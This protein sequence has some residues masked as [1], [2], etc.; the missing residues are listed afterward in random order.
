MHPL[1]LVDQPEHSLPY[2]T[3]L[4]SQ[5]PTGLTLALSEKP[6]RLLL[7]RLT[8]A[9]KLAWG[10]AGGYQQ[11]WQAPDLQVLVSATPQ[12]LPSACDRLWVYPLEYHWE[13]EDLEISLSERQ[14]QWAE[15]SPTPVDEDALQQLLKRPLSGFSLP[16]IDPL[17]AEVEACAQA[18]LQ[19]EN[20]ALAW[21]SELGARYRQLMDL[22]LWQLRLMAHGRPVIEAAAQRLIDKP[23]DLA[24]QLV[25]LLYKRRYR[26][27]PDLAADH[28]LTAALQHYHTALGSCLSLLAPEPNPCV[29][30]GTVTYNRVGPLQRLVEGLLA[31]RY[32]HWQ[33]D[34]ID[35]GS[36]DETAAYCQNL[37]QDPRVQGRVRVTRLPENQG[38]QHVGKLYQDLLH[39]CQSEWFM[40]LSDDDWLMPEHL[41]LSFDLLARYPW[42]AMVTGTYQTYRPD[43]S[44]DFC[45]GP[46]YAQAQVADTQ[47]EL[48]RPALA[49]VCPQGCIVRRSLLRE[50][51]PYDSLL[52]SDTDTYAT[53]DFLIAMKMLAGFEVGYIPQVITG[54][55]VSD[56][57]AF[58]GHDYTYDMS[59]L[60]AGIVT[61]SEALFGP[62]AYPQQ[63][64]QFFLDRVIDGMIQ[65]HLRALLHEAP[66][67]TLRERLQAKQQGW[68]TFAQ[69]R[70]TVLPSCSPEAPILLKLPPGFTF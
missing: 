25:L 58:A 8:L 45:Y 42:L 11:A 2:F 32:P 19:V 31:Q 68:E 35:H 57:T 26:P 13:G 10:Q 55:T 67:D 9:W 18:W 1:I 60:L 38:V 22:A 39:Q 28:P 27:A 24:A 41:A 62:G 51:A 48:Q 53:W 29:T 15:E 34:L 56:Q 47:T 3:L 16:L 33:L 61:D 69:V 4:A 12:P 44:K 54:F 23:S 66:L 63:L 7:Q 46:I 6:S 5:Q 14:A 64:S 21:E 59:R 40:L 36:T 43:G 49:G 20:V 17:L 30:I 50:F 52:K 70:R 37:L 65:T